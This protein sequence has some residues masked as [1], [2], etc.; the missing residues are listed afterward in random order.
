MGKTLHVERS[1]V[2]P[3]APERIFAL[4]DDFREWE[5]WSPWEELDPSMAHTYSGPERGVGAVHEWKGNKKAGEGRMEIVGTDPPKR[6]DM[7]LTFIK[8]FK[9]KNTTRFTLAENGPGSTN[10]TWSMDSPMP[11]MMRVA[12][13]F[14]NMD[15]RIGSDFEKGLAKLSSLAGE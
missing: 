7:A 10:V 8:P 4:L 13:I 5:R 15:K 11:F 14:M 12:N 2:I 3:A 6:M 1:A 9:S